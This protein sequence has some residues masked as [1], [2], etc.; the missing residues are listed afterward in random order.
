MRRDVS[1]KGLVIGGGRR[2]GGPRLLRNIGIAVLVVLVALLVSY[3]IYR[4]VVAYAVPGGSVPGDPLV[5]R[6]AESAEAPAVLGYGASSLGYSGRIAVLR[7]V[8]K[9][10][11][12]GASHGRLLGDEVAALADAMDPSIE[13]SVGTGGLFGESTHDARLR[14]RYRQLDDGIPGHQLIE[15]AGV[16]RGSSRTAASAPSYEDL[17][18][19]QAVFDVGS[20]VPWSSA[21][22]TRTLARSLSFVATLRGASGDRL[23][24]GRSFAMPGLSDE[25][26]AAAR[27]VVVSFVRADAVIPYAS[28][29][30]P[31]LVGVVSGVNAEG[32]AVM[33]HPVRTADVR[34]TRA[35]QPVALVA[36]DVLENARTLD[37]AIGIIE[38]A[39]PL[40]AA[41]FVIVDGN[42]R[43]WA[44][45]ERSPSHVV[46]VRNRTPA[47]IG[48]TFE[49]DEFADDPENDRARRTHPSVMRAQRMA[50][51]LGTA[52][53]TPAEVAALLRDTRGKGGTMLPP[54]HRGAA[55][56]LAAVHTALFDASG[57]VLWVSE[58]PGASG[59]FRA[60]DLRYELRGEGARPA[61]PSDIP[62]DPELDAGAAEALA[63]ARADLRA[64]R[65][66]WH[67]GHRTRARE[68]VQRA[69]AQ[70][71]TIP[72]GLELA[73]AYARSAGDRELAAE[74]YKKYLE[75]G[76]DDLAAEDE[77]RAILRDQ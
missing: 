25:G 13:D 38:Q 26:E 2:I 67:E 9:P 20:A 21:R 51:L 57:M 49:S 63:R 7:L 40:G 34:T 55:Q 8:G 32:I 72:E 29:G 31:G 12:L 68:R 53:A 6:A 44:V 1:D 28:V 35:A 75:V 48:D 14:W 36:R 18:R 45:V 22:R 58:G 61:P 76:P 46:A 43:A 30:W 33:V 59:R 64:A 24:L 69:L 74:L 41:A 60:F 50:Q 3:I 73:A 62:A 65:R 37:D 39:K 77:A 10:H 11:T 52:L 70:V 66:A 47:V 15:I 5:M 23:L 42:R 4:R 27:N 71:P 54:G 56:D 17:V 16:V 19:Q